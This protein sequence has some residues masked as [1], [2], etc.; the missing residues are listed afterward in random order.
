[1]IKIKQFENV[2][3]ITKLS[4]GEDLG[5]INIIYAPNG[6]AKSSICDAIEKISNGEDVSDIYGVSPKPTYE[7]IVDGKIVTQNAKDTFNVVCFSG[8]DTYDYDKENEGLIKLAVSSSVK[9]QVSASKTKIDFY[10]KEIEKII[11]VVFG[12]DFGKKK[13]NDALNYIVN[14]DSNRNVLVKISSLFADDQYDTLDEKFTLED[15][16]LFA[17]PKV[18]TTIHKQNVIEKGKEYVEIIDK[19]MKTDVFDEKFTYF[20]LNSIYQ[21][22]LANNYFDDSKKRLLKINGIEYSKVEIDNFLNNKAEEIFGSKELSSVF[23]SVKKDITKNKETSNLFEFLKKKPSLLL[24]IDNYGK[25][26]LSV[27]ASLFSK[28]QLKSLKELYQS[29]DAENKFIE[30]I[31]EER[32]NDTKIHEI[33]SR[34]NK[35]FSTTQFDLQIKNKLDSYLGTNVPTFVKCSKITGQEISNPDSLRFSTGEKRTYNFINLIIDIES[36]RDGSPLTIIFDDAAESFDYKNKYG[37]IDYIV[38]LSED[39][40]LQIIVLTHNFDFYRS[41]V[42][43]IHDTDKKQFFAYRNSNNEVTIEDSSKGYYLN[44]S[45]FNQWK[46][47]PKIEQYLS[48]IGFTRQIFQF[49]SNSRDPKVLK[50]DS[51]LHFFE[52]NTDKC[53]FKDLQSVLSS[54]NIQFPVSLNITDN[55]LKTLNGVALNISTGIINETDL[56]YKLTLGLALRIFFERIIFLEYKNVNGVSLIIQNEFGRSRELLQEA[57][58]LFSVDDYLCLVEINS[59]NPSYVHINSFMYEPLIDVGIEKLAELFDWLIVK[60]SKYKL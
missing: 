42:L 58:K 21:T 57:K 18:D 43:A 36:K 7:L 17:T 51:Y 45:S 39:N 6:T 26:V 5:R 55:Y 60:N 49:Q 27:F 38:S 30:K 28:E 29:I 34:F 22:A 16:Y 3:G 11:R 35:E 46:S 12:S 59:I 15:F 37:I 13:C 8:I 4:G 19:R 2:F 14:F 9:K 20:N 23:E 48:L 56:E 41:V 24:K 25:L 32:V 50:L 52:G 10:I 53:D 33:W 44:F 31:L 1:M 40:N 54:I 47:N